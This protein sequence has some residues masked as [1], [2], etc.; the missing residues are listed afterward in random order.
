[1][2]ART[3]WNSRVTILFKWNP[4]DPI[5]WLS[6]TA[7]DE[8]AEYYD[9]EFLARLGITKLKVP[10]KEFWPPSGPRWDGLAKTVSGKLILVEAKAHIGEVI[11]YGSAATNPKSI[12][13]IGKALAKAK[14]AFGATDDAP[15]E[16]PFYQYGLCPTP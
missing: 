15:W 7:S 12:C 8:Y 4:T 3:P 10:L 14:K 6:P 2:N 16:T 1:M 5:S 13:K 11:K 9:E